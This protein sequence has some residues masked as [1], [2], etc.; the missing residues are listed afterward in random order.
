M[1]AK[2]DVIGM[3]F[4]RLLVLDDGDKSPNGRR[5]V[6][7][8]C[9]CGKITIVDPR[10]LRSGDTRSCG[11]LQKE[12]V[13]RSVIALHTTHGQSRSSEYNTWIKIRDRCTNPRNLKFK[14]YGYRGIKV[15][16]DWLES[17]DAFFRD[18]GEKPRKSWSIDRID[19]NGDYEPNNCR[20]ADPKTQSRNKRSHRIVELEGV[21]MPLSQACEIAGVNY[22][23]ALYRLN[24]GKHWMPLPPAPL[25][26]LEGR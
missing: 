14:D 20:W 13:S 17:F 10:S 23:S 16:H 22:R 19:V 15:C 9:D 12:A 6:K 7:C 4:E 21:S 25:A 18:M 11:C 3:R 5:T 26:L 24:T 2:I 8:V 1:P